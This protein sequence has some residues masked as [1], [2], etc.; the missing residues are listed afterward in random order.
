[1]AKPVYELWELVITVSQFVNDV[2]CI[3]L[4]S[5]LVGTKVLVAL[6]PLAPHAHKVPDVLIAIEIAAPVEDVSAKPLLQLV[7]VPT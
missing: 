7:S 6:F 4:F 1:M 3:G 5:K 2:I